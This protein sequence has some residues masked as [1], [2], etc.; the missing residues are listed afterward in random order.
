MIGNG[1]WFEFDEVRGKIIIDGPMTTDLS[2]AAEEM[3]KYVRRAHGMFLPIQR[4]VLS[5]ST[6][7]AIVVRI[8]A[9]RLATVEED[10]FAITYRN[11]NVFIEGNGIRSV[12]YGTYRFLE[13]YAGMRWLTPDH[14]VIYEPTD[15]KVWIE[16][17][18]DR[19]DFRRRGIILE[20]VQ[21]ASYA[22]GVIDWMSKNGCDLLM[23]TIEFWDEHQAAL[24][25]EMQARQLRLGLGG[26]SLDRFLS[27]GDY[28]EVHP[29]WFAWY[30]GG[31]VAA[32]PCFSNQE[33]IAFL[34]GRIV[35]YCRQEPDMDTLSL[36][37]NDNKY[38]CQCPSCSTQSFVSNYT[39]FLETVRDQ[40]EADGQSVRIQMLAYNA[41]I[42]WTMLE[43]MPE[44]ASLDVMVACWGRDYRQT[45]GS[46]AGDRDERFRRI[47]ADWGQAC[48]QRY[49]SSLSVYE[50]YAD[51]WMM[52]SLFP[53]LA[54]TICKDIEEYRSMGVQEMICLLLPYEKSVRIMQEEIMGLPRE[55]NLA[56][57]EFNSETPVM[58][59]NLYMFARKLWN[60]SL[61]E[62]GLIDEYCRAAFGQHGD[63]GKTLLYALEQQLAQLTVYNTRW[64]K[65]RYTDVWIRDHRSKGKAV[66]TGVSPWA[67]EE[68][69]PE[70]PAERSEVSR[71]IV[72]ELEDVWHKAA[73]QGAHSDESTLLYQAL[74]QYFRYVIQKLRSI[75]KQSSAQS[76][77]IRQETEEAMSDLT[78]ALQ[79]ETEIRGWDAL[80]FAH[81]LRDPNVL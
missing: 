63:T 40:L 81:R 15:R 57:R 46:P 37:P 14:E 68:D 48:S 16:E 56:D 69:E 66:V 21:S 26:H 55:N 5:E 24:R 22:I 19:P 11:G 62:A 32:Q 33:G 2:F 80:H 53:P 9:E 23:M 31:R 42:E 17:R 67:K 7:N 34:I 44:A 25:P 52:T 10:G 36:F 3:Q 78:E 72:E 38:F 12:L 35:D 20:G 13:L 75:D 30:E 61:D 29:E 51:Y 47:V 49:H 18:H 73:H 65:L 28:F 70:I 64:F 41:Q 76:K 6:Q 8:M 71:R 54:R 74:T 4:G 39:T 43:S 50:Y 79:I 27:P 58:W 60:S 59:L 45:I 77:L 1:C